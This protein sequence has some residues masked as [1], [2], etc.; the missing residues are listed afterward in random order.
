MS[1]LLN[2]GVT[3]VNAAQGQLV[4]TSHNIANADVAG[5]HRQKVIQTT[6]YPTFTGAGFFGNGTQIVTV[7]RAYDQFLENQVLYTAN[8]HAEYETYANQIS[9]IDNLLADPA[10]GLSPAMDEFFAGV[11]EVAANPTNVAA[12]QAL[13]STTQS[14]VTRFQGL[15]SRLTE[16]REGV[17]YE[18]HSVVGQINTYA[19]EIA[20]LNQR[21]LVAQASGSA[22]P[23][24]DLLDQ[25]WQ[26]VSELNEFIKVSTQ[27]QDDGSLSVFIGTGQSLVIGNVTTTLATVRNENDP[28]RSDIALISPSGA[29]IVLP[30]HALSGG[31]LAGLLD[32]RRESLDATQNRLGLIAATLGLAFNDQHKLGVDLDG[33]LGLDFFSL[34]SPDVIPDGSAV[35]E[36]DTGNFAQL[37]DA[38]YEL[39]YDGTNYVITNLSTKLSKTLVGTTDT[40]EGLRIDVSAS[41]LLAGETALIKPTRYMAR[42]IALAINDPRAVAAGNPVSASVPVNNFG[43]AK[44]GNIVM[45]DATDA[46][47]PYP[48][49]VTLTYNAGALTMA[50]DPAAGFTIS[51]ATYDPATENAGKTF[52]ITYASGGSFDFTLS[53]VPENGDTFTFQKTEAGVADN[54][55]ANLLGALQN[56]KLMLDSGTGPTAT[57][58]T[59]YS[60]LVNRVGNKTHEVQTNEETQKLLNAQARD[61]RDALSAVNLDEEAANLIRYQQAYQA[62][63]QVMTVAQRLFDELL[64]IAR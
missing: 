52:T 30:E 12:R 39:S 18:L 44:V 13:L 40:F 51:P 20:D 47:N 63:A 2:I 16:I 28:Q 15:N 55:N 41:T 3:G 50:T 46:L 53:G 21:I 11:Q 59:A 35:V 1:S 5:Y 25:R 33:K 8:R 54:R 31:Q 61:T 57:L 24:N 36:F 7:N 29:S 32:F 62:C 58:G 23:A 22:H 19:T 6:L 42:D 60:Q 10:A 9:Q 4:T 38:D 48:W 64:S 45:N 37:T 49:N 26:L 17:E 34:P 43:T 14:L 56:T 27:E